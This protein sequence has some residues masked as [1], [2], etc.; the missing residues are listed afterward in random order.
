MPLCWS[1]CF[2]APMPS[3]ANGNCPSRPLTPWIAAPLGSV[4]TVS[5]RG[6]PAG[7]YDISVATGLLEDELDPHPA[8]K[9]AANSSTMRLRRR[10][11]S[12]LDPQLTAASAGLNQDKC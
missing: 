12:A 6:D 4:W 10:I 2:N 1:R 9:I 5:T 7:R 11:K 8:T 3:E